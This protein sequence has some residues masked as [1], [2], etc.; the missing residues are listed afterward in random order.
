MKD[1][2]AVLFTTKPIYRRV[3]AVIREKL[4][5]AQ[6]EFDQGVAKIEAETTAKIDN[7]YAEEST[8]KAKLADELV[9]SVLGN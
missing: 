8:R 5:A 6:M 2:L 1:T 9:K 7:L 4:K 3:F